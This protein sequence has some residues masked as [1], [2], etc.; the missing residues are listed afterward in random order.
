[1]QN[2]YQQT[3]YKGNGSY[4][5]VPP[6]GAELP[7]YSESD[8]EKSAPA[9]FNPAPN[10][11]PSPNKDSIYLPLIKRRVSKKTFWIVVGV[12]AGVVVV[13]IIV[14]VAV[15]VS[16]SKNKNDNSGGRN[17]QGAKGGKTGN[18]GS[19][20]NGFD[21]GDGVD[22][23]DG[24][25]TGDDGSGTPDGGSSSTDPCQQLVDLGAPWKDISDCLYQQHVTTME[26]IDNFDGSDDYKYT[27]Y[28]NPY[29]SAGSTGTD[30]PDGK[31]KDI[32]R[33]VDLVLK[34]EKAGKLLHGGPTSFHGKLGS[35]GKG[36]PRQAFHHLSKPSIKAEKALKSLGD[37]G[38]KS[39]KQPKTDGKTDGKKSN[40]EAHDGKKIPK[41]NPHNKVPGKSNEKTHENPDDRKTDGKPTKIPGK[42]N[43]KPHG[44]DDRKTDGKPT[45]APA[46]SNEK[47]HGGPEEKAP[48]KPSLTAAV[49]GLKDSNKIVR[50]RA[51][52]FEVD[53]LIK[54]AYQALQ[55]R[56]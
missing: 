4:M 48:R 21:S 27:W 45:K 53:P 2:S 39:P 5:A 20:G 22:G 10:F 15:G 3:P 28:T 38:S 35:T 55:K 26:I 56:E 29:A 40:D 46:N 19:G 44:N 9:N 11:R 7:H 34:L 17:A 1:M 14:G 50:A 47:S 49:R 54:A 24:F 31:A 12:V 23:G 52:G 25:D 42:S 51:V 32:S 41:P 18:S 37:H 13:A 6:T 36:A 8:I 30:K 33:T 16:K 43:E